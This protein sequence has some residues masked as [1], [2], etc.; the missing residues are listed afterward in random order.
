MPRYAAFLRAVNLGS[1]NKASKERLRELF[2]DA[3]LR[4][5]ATFR[6]SGNVIF[7]AD[8]ATAG[9]LT[10]L[11]EK[12]LADGLG[13]AVPV[14]LRSERELR[15]IAA[16]QPFERAA[17]EASKGK[18]QVSLLSRPPSKA[19]RGKVLALATE[20]DRLAFGRRELFWLPRGGTQESELDQQTIAKLLGPATMRTMGTVEQIAA[21]FFG[22]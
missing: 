15:A 7:S 13:F 1:V 6:T 20:A 8:R 17:V 19:A 18:L 9:K 11:I 2:E 5:V 4:D 22:A 12:S 21:K 10:T 14:Y 16:E 3:G